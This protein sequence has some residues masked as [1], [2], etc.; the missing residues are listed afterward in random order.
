MLRLA[1]VVAAVRRVA[2]QVEGSIAEM[3]AQ[4]KPVLITGRVAEAAALVRRPRP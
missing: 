2:R 1:V 3:A 4:L